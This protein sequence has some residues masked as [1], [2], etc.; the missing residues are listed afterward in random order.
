MKEF[1]KGFV[2]GAATA[3]YQIEGAH[4]ADGKGPNVWDEFCRKPGA[5]WSGHTGNDACQHYQNFRGDVKLMKEMGLQAYRFSISWS[6]V[7]PSGCGAVNSNGLDFYS[8]LVDALL[9]A[10]ITPYA[11]LFHWDYP[12]ALYER[13]GWLAD[14]SPLWFADY[15]QVV[16]QVLGDRVRN[17]MTLNEP[18]I[19]LGCGHREGNHAPGI[20]LDNR[21]F[22]F[23]LKNTMLAHGDAVRVLRANDSGCQ[24]GYA[25]HCITAVPKTES[26]ADI[27]ASER[28][29]WG[30][31]PNRNHWQQRLYLDPPLAGK[32][33]TDIEKTMTGRDDSTMPDDWARMSPRLDFLGLN[34][35]CG[36]EVSAAESGEI[37]E[38]VDPA[39]MPRTLFD[40]PIRPAGIYWAVRSHY[41]RYQLPI[42]I[43][44]NG[45]SN[46][47][48][49][50]EDGL[51]HD[52]QR[53]DFLIRYLG[54]LHRAIEEGIPV[55][56]YFH[57]SLMDNFEWAEG[58]KQR[59]GLIHV[60]Y[61]TLKRTPKESSKFYA[62]VIS[63]NALPS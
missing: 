46:M 2:W 27:E 26:P 63:Q 22:F 5:V 6:R 28:Y 1:P 45:L 13:G 53:T 14:D 55:H 60:D 62:K 56:G 49:V 10:G 51:V 29:N 31:N 11:T 8:Q 39:G 52:P 38:H 59:F 12:Q 42:F 23:A 17:W 40:W 48:W 25:P 20:K 16:A 9:E 24:I 41:E 54:Q 50:H 36:P 19:F 37:K 32:W 58:Y 47:D 30:E 61:E 4:N 43:T 3:A 18:G 57:W 15:A 35:Y 33:P 7:L 44:E 21:S 34:Y